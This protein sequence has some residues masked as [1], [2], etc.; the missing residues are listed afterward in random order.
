MLLRRGV[1]LL[2]GFARHLQLT[3]QG[4][5]LIL[6]IEA[7]HPVLIEPS[8]ILFFKLSM[9]SGHH[10]LSVWSMRAPRTL[11][12]RRRRNTMKIAVGQKTLRGLRQRVAF[13]IQLAQVTIR[14]K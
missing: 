8:L 12:R 7:G 9:P 2:Q 10:A 3:S 14:K 1:T 11:Q 13:E 5:E 6:V 4:F